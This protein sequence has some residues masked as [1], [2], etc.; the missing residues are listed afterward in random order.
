ML[1]LGAWALGRLVRPRPRGRLIIL[2]PTTHAPCRSLSALAPCLLVEFCAQLANSNFPWNVEKAV[3]GRSS[4]EGKSIERRATI[5]R[6]ITSQLFGNLAAIHGWSVVHRDVKGANLLLAEKERR[7]KLSELP[8]NCQD[9]HTLVGAAHSGAPAAASSRVAAA[10]S[11]HRSN[12]TR[13]W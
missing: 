7:F 3:M 13:A 5:I 8:R 4:E 10:P 1:F 2:H 12:T 9:G 11:T 6:R